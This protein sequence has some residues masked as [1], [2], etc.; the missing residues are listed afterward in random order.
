MQ[1]V[2]VIDSSPDL[3]TSVTRRLTRRF[4]DVWGQTFPFDSFVYRDLGRTPPPHVDGE[5]IRA[6][7]TEPAKRTEEQA[8][9]VSLSEQYI[10]ELE[11]ADVIVLGV[12]MHNFSIPSGFKA[13]I[14]H[15]ARAGRTFRY[16]ED[17]PEGLLKGKRVV[18]L[19]SRGGNYAEGSPAAPMDMQAPYLRMILGFMGLD[20]VTFVHAQGTAL[21][22]EGRDAAERE[23]E[24]LVKGL[25][26]QQKAA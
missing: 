7:G 1:R 2:L 24:A 10:E 13:Y 11:G 18:V 3:K 16:T 25:K 6:F 4:V 12:P 5:T 9:R 26:A 8:I 21:G 20:D 17:G 19:T 22:A 23:I 14:D 15:V